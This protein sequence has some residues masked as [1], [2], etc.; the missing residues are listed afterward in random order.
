ME[1]PTEGASEKPDHEA[2]PPLA[3]NQLPLTPS[4][5]PWSNRSILRS[6]RKRSLSSQDRPIGVSK[7][8]LLGTD[9]KY[10]ISI[11]KIYENHRA[12]K[13]KKYSGLVIQDSDQICEDID[14][15]LFKN[16]LEDPNFSLFNSEKSPRFQK[17]CEQLKGYYG[18]IL[19]GPIK[20]LSLLKSILDK[21]PLWYSKNA[22]KKDV[23]EFIKNL[24]KAISSLTEVDVNLHTFLDK[25]SSIKEHLIRRCVI[26]AIGQ[27]YL[28]CLRTFAQENAFEELQNI[29][30]RNS[31]LASALLA[32]RAKPTQKKDISSCP[33]VILPLT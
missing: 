13:A 3:L 30:L 9:P 2:I 23:R 33:I 14:Y 32:L 8:A 16:M 26:T 27:N 28:D 21:Y 18:V 1:E 31:A 7:W 22:K 5:E 17:F 15:Q 11:F 24:K 4:D 25:V 29:S 12:S 10:A 19:E 6:V 20:R